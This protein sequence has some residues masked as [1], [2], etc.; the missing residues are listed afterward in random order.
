M[1]GITVTREGQLLE[2]QGKPSTRPGEVLCITF[3]GT[4]WRYR[5]H[6]HRR[7]RH[8]WLG[9]PLRLYCRWF[10]FGWDSDFGF[11]RPRR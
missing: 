2:Q 6:E 7:R 3:R 9:E 8:R 5:N 11:V 10:Q 1:V 4:V